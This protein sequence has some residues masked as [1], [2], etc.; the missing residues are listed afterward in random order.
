MQQTYRRPRVVATGD[1]RDLTAGK[2]N[3]ISDPRGG[4]G[5]KDFYS[6]T[7]SNVAP[8]PER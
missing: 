7:V 2:Q 8:L 1:V 3:R 6:D 4:M 5:P